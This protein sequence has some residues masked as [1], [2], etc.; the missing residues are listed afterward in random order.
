MAI[1]GALV[2]RRAVVGLGEAVLAI[3]LGAAL[4]TGTASA[5]SLTWPPVSAIQS[6][7]PTNG[8]YVTTIAIRS[9]LSAIP[10]DATVGFAYVREEEW[11]GGAGAAAPNVDW[12]SPA[13]GQAPASF[14]GVQNGSDN[15][16]KNENQM[17]NTYV[18]VTSFVQNWLDGVWANDGM[19]APVQIPNN[20]GCVNGATSLGTNLMT[21]PFTYYSL[22][23]TAPGVAQVYSGSGTQVNLSWGPGGNTD[24]TD[25]LVQRQ[26]VGGG[27]SPGWTTIDEAS[28][29]QTSFRTT[30]QVCGTAYRYRV[31][32][33]QTYTVEGNSQ[34]PKTITTFATSPPTDQWDE[35]PC[36]E[37]FNGATASS[38]TVSWPTVT[39]QT[40][41]EIVWCEEGTP[42]GG[43]SCTQ[44]RVDL[45]AGTGSVTL[46]GLTPNAEYAVWAC[47]TTNA[48]GCP[49]VNA[50]TY[51]AA[52][53]L[54][55][56]NNPSGVAYDQ[57]PLIW[58]TAGDAPGT[59]FDLTQAAYSPNGSRGGW[60]QIYRGSATSFTTRNQGAGGSWAYEVSAV[61]AGYDSQ[62][63]A[64]SGVFIQVASTPI[65][66]ATGPTT[67]T[68]SWPVV[69]NETQ[70]A[71]QC[72]SVSGNWS[73]QGTSTTTSWDVAGLRPDTGYYCATYATAGNQGIPW[74][75]QS[76][77]V[78]TDAA[79][80]TGAVLGGITQTAVTMSW[81]A[82]GNRS[83]TQYNAVL[84]SCANTSNSVAGSG[85]VEATS[86]P[87]TGL[88]PGVCYVG[89]VQA[90]NRAGAETGLDWTG[91]AA[92]V[93]AQ[94]TGFSGAAGGLGWS[95]TAGRGYVHLSWNP[96]PG[97][98]GYDVLVWDGATYETFDVGQADSWSSRQALIY[99]PDASLYPNVAKASKNPPLFSASAGGMNL[100][101]L[102]HDLYCTAGTYYC[103]NDAQNYWFAVDAYNASGNSD[104]F[105][106]GCAGDCYQPTLPLQ[107]DPNAPTV[108]SW[109]LNNGSAYTY[110]SQVSYSLAASESPSG[111]AAYALSNDG[112]SWTTVA[113]AGCGARQVASCQASLLARGNW[114]LT[115]GPGSKTVYAKVESTAGVW[116]APAPAVVYV[117]ADQT[118]PTVNVT[119][120]GGA[121][122]TNKTAAWVGVS[123]SDPVTKQADLT[124]WAR[125]STDG[126]QAWS[127]WTSEGA[128]TS[129]TTSVVIP[130]GASGQRSVLVE[131]QDSNDNRGQGGSSIQYIDPSGPQAGASTAGLAPCASTA[132]LPLPSGASVQC[133]RQPQVTVRL[134]PPS[135]AVE[136]RASLSG[137]T[138]GPWQAVASDMPVNLGTAPGLKT[139]W[140]EYRD[141]SGN[142]TASGNHN[143]AYYVY[144]PGPPKV[145]AAWVGNASSTTPSDNATVTLQASDDVSAGLQVQVTEN[146]SILA[147]GAYTNSI[148]L[149]L[150]GSGFQDVQVT[151]RDAAGNATTAQLGI[152][153]Q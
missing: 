1:D 142:V 137:V 109:S 90:R 45:S 123:V 29:S 3:A 31:E 72:R 128:A 77:E 35:Y 13:A 115:P 16:T 110:A 86:W 153:V 56:H 143:P 117:N 40:N 14:Y 60:S 149:T 27:G 97:A 37:A 12:W 130:G 122:A 79:Q 141:A 87:A 30:D 148:P 46:T 76:A 93:P 126:G 48:W 49:M 80:P 15:L 47:S 55:P 83:G 11:Q 95:P 20:Y 9:D 96:A 61:S 127:A 111:I 33:Q 150:K 50:W 120:D 134:A 78:Y 18:N 24:I 140:V 118:V 139:V 8:N 43:V 52:P 63:P 5:N 91:K 10:A 101:D 84:Y 125:F 22:P 7:C 132:G 44:Q 98:T 105:Q 102:P 69:A 75:Q 54:S 138:W 38:V 64:R 103:S 119:L 58:T 94:P 51:A 100:R 17:P 71:V 6:W 53:I 34:A 116:S 136:L 23:L 145:E 4:W 85:W 104:A 65:L 121:A 21:P 99:P 67:A 129:W 74:W 144:D 59:L 89:W 131:V 26:T 146:G 42:A 32:V 41:P 106:G 114:S 147:G 70:T 82:A 81:A 133:T 36:S 152:Y 19:S 107:T 66:T 57:Q 135:S 73:Y 2:R 92:T 68:L 39:P 88:K 62:T 113:V 151:V 124:F 108:T 112:N 28:A 25:Y